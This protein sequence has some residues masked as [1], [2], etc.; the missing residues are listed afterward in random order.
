V[1]AG[2][3]NGK[4]SSGTVAGRLLPRHLEDLRRS[5][6]SEEQIAACG[7]Y[8][9][10]DPARVAEL[11]R[12]RSPAKLLGSCLVIPFPG[13]P[14][15]ARV[16]PDSP[17]QD[18]KSPGK[19]IKYESPLRSANRAFIPPGTRDLLPDVS[20]SLIITEGEKKAAKAD[21]EGFPCLGLVGVYGWQKKRVAESAARELIE[22]LKSVAWVSRAVFICYDSDVRGKPEV[23][24]AEWHL[25]QALEDAGAVV[26]VVRLPDGAK[27]E[28]GQPAKVGLDD[29]LVSK[30]ADAGKAFE[31][32]LY[33]A[34]PAARPTDKRP[35][36][37][38][39]VEEHRA[40]ELAVR[41]LARG[42]P[43]IYQRGGLLVRVARTLRCDRG[44]G[45]TSAGLRI[46]AVP[47]PD[48]RTRLTR[49]AQFVQ[50]R[51]DPPKTQRT[52][53][54]QWLV[55]G[56]DAL[57]AWPEVRLLEGVIEAPVLRSDGS[58]V[59][60]PG[61]DPRTGLLYEPAGVF[62]RVPSAPGKADAEQAMAVL[63]DV[64]ADFPFASEAHRST[65]VAALLTVLARFAFDGPAP[66]FLL[67]ANIRGAGKG[68]LADLVAAIALGRDLARMPYSHD[69]DE[70]RK[71]ITAV[72]LQGE[73]LILLDNVDVLGDPHLDAALTSTSWQGRVLGK[74]QQPKLPLNIT[75]F[76]TGN[77]VVLMAD[78]VRRVCHCRLESP[79]EKPEERT[80]F[81]HPDLL[82]WATRERASLLVAALTVLAAYCKAGWP[83]Q[84]LRP[85]GSYEGWSGLIRGA[86]VWAG[87]PDPGETRLEANRRMDLS[88]ATLRGLLEGWKQ[89]DTDGQGLTAA[90]A[91]K[92]LK[93]NPDCATLLR[94]VLAEAFDLKP[95]DL[96]SAKRLGKKLASM[97]GR[98]AGG[99]CFG[100]REGHGGVKVWGVRPPGHGGFG[101]F[102]GFPQL[103]IGSRED[104][105]EIVS[106]HKESESEKA[107]KATKPTTAADWT[108]GT[109]RV[110]VPFSGP[111][112]F[113]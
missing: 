44:D 106:A 32:L 53:P 94:E 26:K 113:Y 87:Q 31:Q 102:G 4:P 24:W 33:E 51:G 56:V 59:Q 49:V 105:E 28:D 86:L 42:D 15:Y 22:D 37:V 8:S 79:E 12:W 85:W 93:D 27:G 69:F 2:S 77:N 20:R 92:K 5:G 62:P 13:A 6:L 66:L 107:T 97:L 36:V 18:R 64:V 50:Q 40:I 81:K 7:F 80:G 39:G 19:V 108:D 21:Q 29:F 84:Q 30:G 61:Y 60:E 111:G 58:V 47:L 101:G 1:T 68:L 89:L 35:A 72:A 83:A 110:E 3:N 98:V 23:Q 38:V 25:A 10:S 17:R 41:A 95:G 46:E 96:P 48:L 75:W 9:C 112:G 34:Q 100:Q 88:G 78:T 82:A 63:L 104:M 74:S 91:V 109:P 45:R 73:R 67:D 52:R 70:T 43:G 16:K 11:L 103:P 71:N 14:G 99:E 90:Q 76:A 55:Q 54:P 57:G 65:W